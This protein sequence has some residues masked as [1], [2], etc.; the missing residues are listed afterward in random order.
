MTTETTCLSSIWQTDIMVRNWLTVHGR[1]EDYRELAPMDGTWYDGV[2]S[3]AL[4][5]I[6]PMIAL[7][8]HP[9]NVWTIRDFLQNADDLLAGIEKEALRIMGRSSGRPDLRSKLKNGVVTVDQ[10]IV[11][12][13]SGGVYENIVRVASVLDGKSTGNGNF[14][15]SIYPASQPQYLEMVKRGL[16]ATLMEA[17]VTL[18]SAFC[19]PC[20]GAGDVPANNNFSI[21]HTTRNFPNREGSKPGEGQTA[22]VALMDARSIAATAAMGGILTPATD[23][24]SPPEEV[25]TPYCFDRTIYE[26]R[27]YRG[28]GKPDKNRDLAF[29]PNITDWPLMP[30]LPENLILFV[31]SAIY[32]Q[33]TTTDELIPSGE[34][35]SYRSN[36]LRLAE[37]TLS[38][39]DPG[40]VARARAILAL[41]ETRKKMTGQ[42]AGPKSG[43][44]E[45]E[46][47]EGDSPVSAR[48]ASPGEVR[49]LFSE[50]RLAGQE[51]HT[52]IGSVVFA[53]KPGD[54]SAREQ[55][56]SCQKVLGGWANIAEEYAT[57]RYRANLVNWGM[58]P[59]ILDDATQNGLQTGD[60]LV[61]RGIRQAL[62]AGLEEIPAML[63]RNGEERR[64]SLRLP[65]LSESER[66]IILAGCLI[67][68]Y[69]KTNTSDR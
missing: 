6:E 32:D 38:R 41:E 26:K 47:H 37:F 61:L 22:Y 5:K 59:F 46:K 28:F 62:S 21:R 10:G 16:A 54:G 24:S 60:R 52:G 33:V 51:G 18:K 27:V 53:L 57:K 2:I 4:D 64:V 55:A 67:N 20:F 35:S 13:C 45:G 14:S 50:L 29:G 36:P 68:H 7:P 19:G 69:A 63:F 15:L 49:A 8:F 42:E 48:M 44:A 17:G 58:L 40:Y 30:A 65:S 9:A 34:T 23:L 25:P 11:A 1:Q 66:K 56:A 31:A 3:I 12:G 39:K 43:D